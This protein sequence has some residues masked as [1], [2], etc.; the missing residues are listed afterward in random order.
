M[1]A[2][3]LDFSAAP[4]VRVRRAPLLGEH[5]EEILA[6]V[7]GLSGREIGRLHDDGIVA[8]VRAARR[9]AAARDAICRGTARTP[10]RHLPAL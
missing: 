2:S 5:T 10:P 1:P 8:V 6:E 7:L 9:P 4:R 3:P